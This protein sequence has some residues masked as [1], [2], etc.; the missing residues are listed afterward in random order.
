[1][2]DGKKADISFYKAILPL[3]RAN[4]FYGDASVICA[5]V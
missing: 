4:V 2:N 5:V 1:M 3:A